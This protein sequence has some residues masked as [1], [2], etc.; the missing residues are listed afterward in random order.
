MKRIHQ[1]AV[2][3]LMALTTTALHT[4]AQDVPEEMYTLQGNTKLVVNEKYRATNEIH[5]ND[6]KSITT[7]LVKAIPIAIK[8]YSYELKLFR[9]TGNGWDTKPGDFHVIRLFHNDKLVLEF[10][11]A[12]GLCNIAPDGVF[13][14]DLRH[15]SAV[16]NEYAIV[17]PLNK[18]VTA[19]I[20][21]GYSSA[22]NTPKV[23]IVVVKGD[24]AAVLLNRNLGIDNVMTGTN[25]L[26]VTFVDSYQEP[27][28]TDDVVSP[29]PTEWH[30]NRYRLFSTPNGTLKFQKIK[31]VKRNDL[32]SV[33]L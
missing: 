18:G 32:R 10:F 22:N 17:C 5:D 1:V 31:E 8:G 14:T 16:P 6:L 7:K 19:I 3:L 15:M 13:D 30:P 23:P 28:K 21:E 29:V 12:D 2:L 20:F 4:R 26:E 11:D 27:A 9:F 33:G 25:L 24:E